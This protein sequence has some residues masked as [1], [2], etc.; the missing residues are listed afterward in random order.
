MCRNG[1]IECRRFS[2]LFIFIAML[3]ISDQVVFTSSLSCTAI[4]YS[5]LSD[6]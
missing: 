5:V 1:S 3:I 2:R 6:I 4:N